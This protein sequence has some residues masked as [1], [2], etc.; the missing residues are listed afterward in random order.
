MRISKSDIFWKS[1]WWSIVCG[2]AVAIA[3]LII[4]S[5]PVFDW[6]FKKVSFVDVLV[7][8]SIAGCYLGAG[9]VGSRVASKYYSDPQK[10]FKGRYVRFSILSFALLVALAFSP[11]SFIMVLWSFIAPYCVILALNNLGQTQV[12]AAARPR[13]RKKLA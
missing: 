12:K 7:V 1:W 8:F 2:S 13:P 5:I 10:R 6:I 3:F 11:I 4:T 9:Y